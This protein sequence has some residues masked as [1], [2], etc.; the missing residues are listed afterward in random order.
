MACAPAPTEPRIHA[1]QLTTRLGAMGHPPGFVSLTVRSDSRRSSH[2][3]SPQVLGID[4]I[5]RT[6]QSSQR[7]YSDPPALRLATARPHRL[8]WNAWHKVLG[9]AR[10]KILMSFGGQLIA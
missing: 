8:H 9:P 5:D 6:S 7:D 2:R 10:S 3:P 4:K 1:A